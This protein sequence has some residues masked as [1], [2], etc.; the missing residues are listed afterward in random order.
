MKCRLNKR[1]S[2]T[3]GLVL[4]VLFPVVVKAAPPQVGDPAPVLGLEKLLQAPKGTTLDWKAL[5]GKVLVLEFWATWCGPCV[6]EIPFLNKLTHSFKDKPVRFISITDE[7]ESVIRPFLEKKPIHGWVGLDTDGSIFKAYGVSSRPTT[8]VVDQ[9]GKLVGWTDPGTLCDHPEILDD[10]LAGRPRKLGGADYKQRSDLLTH[11]GLDIGTLAGDEKNRPLCLIAIRPAA[12]PERKPFANTDRASF[13]RDITLRT[14]IA[15]IH[16][17]AHH[18]IISTVPLSKDKK[19]D[20]VFYWPKGDMKLGRALLRQTIEATFDLSIRR[21]KRVMDVHVLTVSPGV[22]PTLEPGRDRMLYEAKTGQYAPTREVLA[23]MRAGETFFM[24]MGNTNRLADN[25]SFALERPV[26]DETELKGLYSLC[27][28]YDF[29]K[30]NKQLLIKMVNEKYG[31]K[32]T[33]AK[34]E[35]EVLVVEGSSTDSTRNR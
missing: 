4:T 16:E 28:P 3:M 22:Q 11:M 17:I 30:P 32:L 2:I 33:P 24:A 27:L 26:V 25:L 18:R 9:H 1:L 19:Y 20:V 8:V 29:K 6:R 10:L 7:P 34:R 23:R 14:M 15:R 31:L 5:R 35:I 12:P 13:F 21:E